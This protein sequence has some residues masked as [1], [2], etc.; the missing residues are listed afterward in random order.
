MAL[1]RD[2]ELVMRLRKR[3]E[4]LR[5][6]RDFR[7]GMNELS[8][9]VRE[10]QQLGRFRGTPIFKQDIRSIK[11]YQKAIEK[12]RQELV[13]LMKPTVAAR[14]GG[15]TRV[16]IKEFEAIRLEV[17]KFKDSLKV[18]EA[19]SRLKQLENQFEKVRSSIQENVSSI[20]GL[21]KYEKIHG[22]VAG[23]QA[24]KIVGEYK[25]IETEI[26][27]LAK[28]FGVMFTPG[29]TPEKWAER[30]KIAIDKV[31]TSSE[32]LR[33]LFQRLKDLQVL[34]MEQMIASAKKFAS[35]TVSQIGQMERLDAKVAVY[36]KWRMSLEKLKAEFLELEARSKAGGE[37]FRRTTGYAETLQ[38]M[39]D[40]LTNHTAKYAGMNN[41]LAASMI[42][43]VQS[44]MKG[45]PTLRTLSQRFV[46]LANELRPLVQQ[47]RLLAKTREEGAMS[48]T[49]LAKRLELLR[50]IVRRLSNEYVRL[51]TH[52]K[53]LSAS[54][55]QNAEALALLRAQIQSVKGQLV[56]FSKQTKTAN[57]ELQRMARRGAD[58]ARAYDRVSAKG[59]A[60]MLVSQAAWMAGFRLTFGVL[61]AF[62][63]ALNSVIEVQEALVRAMR[64]ARSELMSTSQIWS[65]YR[66]AMVQAR[67]ETGAAMQDLG[68]IMYQLGSAGLTAEESIAALDST[69]ANIIGTEA[70]V[71]DIT[72]LVAGLYNNF[73]DQIYIV[74]GAVRSLSATS[75]E[76]NESLIESAN[77]NQKFLYINNLLVAAFRDNQ[78]E[79]MEL[80][81]GLK[82]M[83]QSGRAANLTLSQMV[84]SL[85]FLNNR[86]IKAGTAGRAMRVIL[87]RITKDARAFA[88]AFDIE[89]DMSQPLDFFKVLRDINKQYQG[90]AVSVEKLGTI[91]KR[92]G[93]RGA[94]AFNLMQRNVDE[95]E[96]T[97]EELEGGL[98]G[99]ARAM[100]DVR[101]QD[102]SSQ[103]KIATANV[104]GFL[105]L[106]ITPLMRAFGGFIQVFT[107]AA[108]TFRA[109]NQL[110]GGTLSLI[111]TVIG[112]A[113]AIAGL[114]IV[115]AKLGSVFNWIRALVLQLI[116]ALGKLGVREEEEIVVLGLYNKV[117]TQATNVR[118]AFTQAVYNQDVAL[119]LS[120]KTLV[121]S[122]PLYG[123]VSKGIKGM[124]AAF[125]AFGTVMKSILWMAIIIGI[126][127]LVDWLRRA[128]ERLEDNRKKWENLKNE[129]LSATNA[130]ETSLQLLK[131]E[132]STTEMVSAA[133]E[134]LKELLSIT[135]TEYGYTNEQRER[136]IKLAQEELELEKELLIYRRAEL[137]RKR[138]E[139][140]IQF[141][142]SMEKYGKVSAGVGEKII[143]WYKDQFS[144]IFKVIGFFEKLLVSNSTKLRWL[145][146]ELNSVNVKLGYFQKRVKELKK[147][148]EIGGLEEGDLAQIN[149]MIAYRELGIQQYKRERKEIR[150][151]MAALGKL[152]MGVDEYNK[153]Q[154]K[155]GKS[156]ELSTEKTKKLQAAYNSLEKNLKTLINSHERRVR[157]LRKE[158]AQL[159][160]SIFRIDI[161]ELDRDL[162]TL[163]RRINFSSNQISLLTSRTQAYENA[164]N[165]ATDSVQKAELN[166]RALRE[167]WDQEGLTLKKENDIFEDMNAARKIWAVM[168]ERLARAIEAR[169][170]R[171]EEG[172]VSIK[173]MEQETE[174]LTMAL[175]DAEIAK[176]KADTALSKTIEKTDEYRRAEMQVTNAWY[177]RIVAMDRL[178]RQRE[179]ESENLRRIEERV[180]LIDL[181]YGKM[182]EKVR[183]KNKLLSESAETSIDEAGY[184]ED[185]VKGWKRANQFLEEGKKKIEEQIKNI[186]NMQ[187]LEFK[188]IDFLEKYGQ[189]QS[190]EAEREK[191]SFESM[192]TA[193]RETLR[194]R[195]GEIADEQRDIADRI[196]SSNKDLI[197]S[198]IEKIDQFKK[199]WQTISE[200]LPAIKVKLDY[201]DELTTFENAFNQLVTKLQNA[202]VKI[203][204]EGTQEETLY[205]GGIVSRYR[206]GLVPARVTAG[207]GYIPPS[208][209][210]GKLSLLNTLNGGR[211][212]PLVPSGISR[213]TGPQGIDRI[214]TLLPKGSYVLSQKG[215]EAYERS[216]KQGATQFQEGG[217]VIGG[218]EIVSPE[219]GQEAPYVGTFIISIEKEGKRKDFPVQGEISVLA[220]L[221]EELEREKLTKLL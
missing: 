23:T 151:Q 82:F 30:F 38:R 177:Q 189:K 102:F 130:L 21:V 94:E 167:A 18:E 206:G 13:A 150:E 138:R 57:E 79:M 7:R 113:G 188:R 99:A 47:Q 66:K 152:I 4:D 197:D 43:V 146:N 217:E 90:Q 25:K 11:E 96:A 65:E 17:E 95:L 107:L 207:E 216:V 212:T 193:M 209:A 155:S 122:L 10:I 136:L 101:L 125:A 89:I 174:R 124:T 158:N 185:N 71:R 77:L 218:E 2:L 61:D 121:T 1:R 213:F 40:R 64:T 15:I 198:L 196:K 144:G 50:E 204:L 6:L 63:S 48:E 69:L 147:M 137:W 29:L 180:L 67:L 34:S 54:S 46:E 173:S 221:K 186:E 192:F 199:K 164:I 45:I 75:K 81:D 187:S 175:E 203:K 156:S 166:V 53:E 129:S 12:T 103:A 117:A 179:L 72:K 139:Q 51:I 109:F 160:E 27:K 220:S 14:G 190:L 8:K 84:G 62:K 111:I 132:A 120:N 194:K 88:E 168:E 126:M 163:G 148:K 191:L 37:A 143:Y 116:V 68:E 219:T 104:E 133:T 200:Q 110:F 169:E 59:F 154:N 157:T 74:D 92:L 183:E 39:L 182:L 5:A 135:S 28:T 20:R 60:N 106:A 128:D 205:K 73:K 86:L 105:R 97:I 41:I 56:L 58:A 184:V 181:T 26:K 141:T 80:R 214:H 19:I 134:R 195:L 178:A 210:Y 112:Y 159:T 162:S 31:G 35:T 87:S 145:G 70:E 211:A 91:F 76:W 3:A 202:Y 32:R 42:N 176:I 153:A 36:E 9:S 123:A 208:S 170:S 201:E 49:I 215:M 142:A 149:R 24:K 85:A 100:R 171:V 118:R 127:E 114:G 83:V 131:D 52:E 140:I 93:L 98:E 44:W 119:Q 108:N 115:F 22:E 33:M 165:K 172:I 16:M 55:I 78:V 161:R